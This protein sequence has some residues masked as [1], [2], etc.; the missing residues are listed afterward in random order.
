MFESARLKLTAWYFVMITLL[1]VSLSA[2]FYSQTN[3]ILQREYDRI[4]NRLQHQVFQN[5][6]GDT[7]VATMPVPISA[8]RLLP[9]DII[10]ARKQILARLILS[11]VMIILVF[12]ALGYWWAGQTLAPIEAAHWAQQRFVTDAAH[13][14]KTPLTALKTSLEVNLMQPKLSASLKKILQENLTD[15]QGLE[16]L[17]Q[18]LLSLT[19]ASRKAITLSPVTVTSVVDSAIRL[20]KPLADQKQIEIKTKLAD[21][22]QQILSQTDAL[23]ELLVILLDNAV[24]YSEPKSVITISTVK[25]LQGLKL[26]VQDQGIGMTSEQ[27]QHIFERFYRADAARNKQVALGF[28]LGLAIASE[29]AQIL[30][31]K[32]EVKSEV[33]KGSSFSVLIPLV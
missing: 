26:M 20:I 22:T 27:Q 32:F 8:R 33:G 5:N 24:K 10:S 12:T 1:T 25:T 9:G 13:E 15:V 31:V 4:E 14:L 21:E 17:V 6:S 23:I 18:S 3:R 30:K 2:L 28:G 16:K 29:L 7:F 19:Q 11:N